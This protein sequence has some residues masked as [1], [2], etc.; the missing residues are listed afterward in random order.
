MTPEDQKAFDECCAAYVKEVKRLYKETEEAD[1][2]TL[3]EKG[4]EVTEVDRAPFK[5]IGETVIEKYCG[6]YPDFKAMLD[7]LHEMGAK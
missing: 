5:A 1:I 4:V 2:N 6:E 7:K 3:K